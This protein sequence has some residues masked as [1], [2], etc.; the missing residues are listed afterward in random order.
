MCAMPPP[1]QCT[2]QASRMMARMIRTSHAKNSTIPGMA[3]PLMVLVLATTASYPPM[4]DLIDRLTGAF[5]AGG[6]AAGAAPADGDEAAG[7]PGLGMREQSAVPGLALARDDRHAPR[8]LLALVLGDI[9]LGSFDRDAFWLEVLTRNTAGR[10]YRAL[11]EGSQPVTNCGGHGLGVAEVGQFIVLSPDGVA[12]P[13]LTVLD[14][15]VAAGAGADAG[16]GG[17]SELHDHGR[18]VILFRCD[19]RQRRSASEIR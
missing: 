2:I 7:V 5:S 16:R 17:A 6:P 8:R 13:V 15:L 4:P 11:T 3:Y 19:A 12:R 1:A 10:E 18:K 14:A 9:D